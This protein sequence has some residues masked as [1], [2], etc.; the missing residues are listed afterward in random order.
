MRYNNSISNHLALIKNCTSGR[1]STLSKEFREALTYSVWV[2]K[3][4]F[5]DRLHSLSFRLQQSCVLGIPD[6]IAVKFLKPEILIGFG[7]RGP[8]AAGMLMPEAAVDEN[9]LPARRKN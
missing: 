2:L 3:F 1:K 9:H 6:E 7:N 4:T 5:L 8:L